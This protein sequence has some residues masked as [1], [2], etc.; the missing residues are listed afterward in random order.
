MRFI[1]FFYL[2]MFMNSSIVANNHEP[3]IAIIG[4]GLAGLT[5]AYRLNQHGFH[6][7]V[8]EARNRVGGR[9]FTATINGKIAEL[10]GQNIR[11]GGD[12][13]CLLSLVNELKLEFIESSFPFTRQYFKDGTFTSEHTYFKECTFD[14]K[15]LGDHLKTLALKSKNMKDVLLGVCNEGDE[16]Y[17]IL[18][19]RLAGYEGNVAEK[20]SVIY[21]DT[22]YHMLLGGSSAAHPNS[23]IAY[24]ELVIKGG[25][26]LLPERLAKELGKHVHLRMPLKKISKNGDG[27]F[28]LIFNDG[29]E[30]TANILVL[31]IPASVFKDITFEHGVIP[32][33][34]LEAIQKIEYGANAKILVPVTCT[35]KNKGP[36]L[37]ECMGAFPTADGSL[38]TLYYRSEDAYFLPHI[39]DTYLKAKDLL[40]AGLTPKCLPKKLPVTARDESFASYNGPVGHSWPNDPYARG[41]YLYIA[42]G[43]ETLLT[44]LSQYEGESIKTLFTPVDKRLFLAG[45]HT[46]TLMDVPGTMEAACQSGESTARIISRILKIWPF[47]KQRT[48]NSDIVV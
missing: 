23:S 43:Q 31:A 9:V 6:V 16:I 17:K 24:K 34:Q 44:E 37:N 14:A 11:D 19:T 2:V 46:S 5:T 25:N 38:I 27:S 21:I 32:Q 35:L 4:A 39:T 22:L 29:H 13:T 10:G 7:D 33:N 15:T 12:A 26:G 45:D 48:T 3:R 20:L 41:S 36:F 1:T 47:D 30:V 8:Y 18:N 28:I 42:P 40:E